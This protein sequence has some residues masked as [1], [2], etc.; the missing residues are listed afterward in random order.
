[1][2]TGSTYARIK[3][4]VASAALPQINLASPEAASGNDGHDH[5]SKFVEAAIRGEE[6]D[7][8]SEWQNLC[9]AIRP[10]AAR[11]RS[12]VAFALNVATGGARILGYNIGRDYKIGELEVP[13]TADLAG[14]TDTHAIIIDLKTGRG[15]VEPAARNRQLRF[16]AACATF[17]Y[18]KE[19]ALVALLHAPPGVE[20][21]WDWAEIDAFDLDFTVTDLL[22]LHRSVQD[23]KALVAA[24]RVPN[25]NEG[26]HCR[27]CPALPVCPAK[28]ALI[29]RI[30]SG[31]EADEM[32]LLKPLSP[33]TAGLAYERLQ[34]GKRLMALVE[35]AVY[36][37][38]DQ[39]G[40]LKLPNGRVLRRESRPGNERLDGDIVW[41][42]L[43]D[44][45]SREVADR[46][47]TRAATKKRLGEV[48]REE[49]GRSGAEKERQV[50]AKVR[51]LGG[52]DRP[53]TE[54]LV[55][56]DVN[57]PAG[58]LKEAV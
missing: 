7:P 33:E 39:Y 3:A 36:G 20:P 10:Y 30:V 24:G 14:A 12:E 43:S 54:K 37:A 58:A 42:V 27:Y 56:V 23:A 32:D 22:E 44:V 1:M 52:A 53:L 18:G 28:T 21:W 41:S 13:G 29:N 50:I 15:E 5:L 51:E 31:M 11:L 35:R 9:E 48:L 26:P 25:V 57:A 38:L 19:S 34:A 8:P 45:A 17:I 40:E 47:V 55:E 46:A 6:Y 16:L 49:Y 4:C 2:I